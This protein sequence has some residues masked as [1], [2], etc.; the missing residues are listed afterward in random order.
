MSS[1]T[2]A[3]GFFVDWDA[4]SRGVLGDVALK[5]ISSYRELDFNDAINLDGSPMDL[6]H[7]SR[8]IDYEQYSQ[9]FQLLGN[10][11][12]V[13]YVLGLYYFKEKAD[14]KNPITFF[15]LLGSPTDKNTYGMDNNS[16]AAFGQ[17]EWRSGFPH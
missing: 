5:S 13:N 14:V 1:Y 3:H 6:F 15:G 16:Y 10:T 17:A 8:C 4:G 2:I 12:S 7:S 11:D 9:E